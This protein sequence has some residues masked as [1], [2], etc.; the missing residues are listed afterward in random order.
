MA[1]YTWQDAGRTMDASTSSNRRRFGAHPSASAKSR[2]S[3]AS[4]SLV[5]FRMRAASRGHV[6]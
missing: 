1:V 6:F 2:A 5:A 3:A 4:E